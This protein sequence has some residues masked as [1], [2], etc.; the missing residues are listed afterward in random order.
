MAIGGYDYD[1][2]INCPFDP[3]YRSVLDALVFVVHD[4]GF[5]VRCALEVATV[6]NGEVRRKNVVSNMTY[7][8]WDLV[9]FHSGV[10][11]L[12]PGD[13]ISTGTP[14]AVVLRDGDVVECRIT[15]FAPLSNPVGDTSG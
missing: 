1:V 7:G 4:C 8:P 11:T 2:F 13:V 6:L 15:G 3:E 5:R 14:G 10:M 12:L 9:S